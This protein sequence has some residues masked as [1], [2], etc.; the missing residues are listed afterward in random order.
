M[1]KPQI[2]I[3]ESLKFEDEEKNRY[4]GKILSDMLHLDGKQCKYYRI[5]TKQEFIEMIDKFQESNY[6]YLHLSCHADQESMATTLDAIRFD[7][8]AKILGPKLRNRRLFLSACQ[9]TNES[10]ASKILPNSQCNSVIGPMKDVLFSDAAIF[11]CSF[12]HLMFK[13]NPKVMKHEMISDY[14]QNTANLFNVSL[15]YFYPTKESQKGYEL[16]NI[17]PRIK[18]FPHKKLK[19][20]KNISN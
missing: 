7:E 1:S 18:T 13:D 8:L 14:L 4:E 11:W 9:M 5:R 3:I 17:S 12:Y 2:F 15:N 19:R 16:E 6:R 20:L 10:L